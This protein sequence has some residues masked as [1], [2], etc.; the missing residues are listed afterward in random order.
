MKQLL[1][2]SLI[3][4]LTVSAFAQ[5]SAKGVQQE[6]STRTEQYYAAF[7]KLDP[8]AMRE[9]FAPDPDLDFF[10]IAP[11]KFAGWAA[12]EKAL[13]RILGKYETLTI[14]PNED[15]KAT[16]RG[17]IAWVTTTFHLDG[18]RKDNKPSVMDGRHTAIWENRAGKWLIVHEHWSLPT[19]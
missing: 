6:F 9:Y 5:P 1:F 18:K 17:D 14:K 8:V 12:Y 10:D 15:L 2:V 4:L 19:P 16:R 13:Q 7:G 3:C 11:M